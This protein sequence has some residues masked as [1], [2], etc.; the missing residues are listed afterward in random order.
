[1]TQFGENLYAQPRSN[2]FLSPSIG[3][4][5]GEILPISQPHLPLKYSANDLITDDES[6]K[7]AIS[8]KTSAS[9][10]KTCLTNL[11]S[12]KYASN[13][14]QNVDALSVLKILSSKKSDHNSEYVPS[15]KN[16]IKPTPG[17][18]K[19]PEQSSSDKVRGWLKLH[20]TRTQSVDIVAE[21][22]KMPASKEPRSTSLIT[23]SSYPDTFA[24]NM[25]YSRFSSLGATSRQGS[26]QMSITSI[27]SNS[28][29][30]AIFFFQIF[31]GACQ[32]IFINFFITFLFYLV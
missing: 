2:P 29:W 13:Q 19:F 11:V 23:S 1:M 5:G 8:K 25:S 18:L 31:W 28:L 22:L 16:V 3:E 14:E 4:S 10:Y 30:S 7:S 32:K 26:S 6:I 15:S 12:L 21:C 9:S 24:T 17:N 20:P 27:I